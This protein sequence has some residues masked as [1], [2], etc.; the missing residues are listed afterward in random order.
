MRDIIIVLLAVYAVW[1]AR[2]IIVLSSILHVI[3]NVI[4]DYYGEE[5]SLE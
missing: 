1:S 4:A 2:K 3:A 5:S